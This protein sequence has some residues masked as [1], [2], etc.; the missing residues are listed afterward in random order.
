MSLIKK[1]AWNIGT[2]GLQEIFLKIL[3]LVNLTI[4]T[5]L[6]LPSDFG[7]VAIAGILITVADQFKDFGIGTAVIQIQKKSEEYIIT[8]FSIRF[9]M[10]I[11]FFGLI[12]IL[13]P[14][15]AD[16][17]NDQLI[18]SVMRVSAIILILE[19]FSFISDTKLRM[20]LKFK[21][22]AISNFLGSVSYSVAVICLAYTGYSYWSIIY[23]RII[24]SIVSAT[25]FWI[26][27]PWKFQLH[28]NKEIRKELFKYAKYTFGVGF[29]GMLLYNVNN[30]VLGKVL[31]STMLGYYVV[32]YTWANF[33]GRE[34]IAIVSHVL[35]PTY[36]SIKSDLP[37]IGNAYLK[38]LKYTAIISIP[39][40][41]G[42]FAI[43]PEFVNIVLGEKWSSSILPLQILS[44]AGLL[45]SINIVTASALLSI[46]KNKILILIAG[47]EFLLII[48]F[49]IPAAKIYGIIGVASLY[50]IVMIALT[51]VTFS[52]IR[53]YLVIEKRKFAEILTPP[54]ISGVLMA[55]CILFLK[56]YI[57]NISLIPEYPLIILIFLILSGIIIY[58]VSI[59]IVTK[60]KIITEIKDLKSN[61]TSR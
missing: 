9:V 18:A 57:K 1:T 37:R 27:N 58:I 16:Y 48:I 60:G 8:G 7:I 46:A 22:I 3:N 41:F 61:L 25:Y 56:D 29:I 4:L 43:A 30:L 42:T 35:F 10:G 17:F 21:T 23:A 40:A 6:L 26:K 36:S 34:I 15:W 38:T 59:F 33:S 53:K 51:P 39:I 13:A 55:T 52:Y 54:I 49:V 11:L 2:I 5:R 19:N 28:F 31:G 45:N 20:E 12:F 32:A 24:Q 44:I 50:S 14:L 47:A